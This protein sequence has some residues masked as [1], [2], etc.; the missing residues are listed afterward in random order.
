VALTFDDGP[1]PVWTPALLELLSALG[2]HAT[3]FPIAGRAAAH[4]DLIARIAQDGHTIGLH[5]DQHVRHSA[6]DEAWGRRDTSQAL[7]RLAA[8]GVSPSLWRTPWGDTAPWSVPLARERGLRIVG[9][10]IDTHDWRGDCAHAMFHAT[11]EALEEGTIVLAHDGLGPGARRDG[12]A[13]TL[14]YVELVA[15][16]ARSNGLTLEALR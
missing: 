5:C 10:T 1:D 8:L 11:R 15:S 9:W 16:Y 14:G 6:R 12:A 2:A 4:P 3:F 7:A 13:E